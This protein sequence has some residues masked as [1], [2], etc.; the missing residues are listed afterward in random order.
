MSDHNPFAAPSN[1]GEVA[2]QSFPGAQQVDFASLQMAG[3]G[4]AIIYGAILFQVLGGIGFGVFGLA[5]IRQLTVAGAG[6]VILF[7]GI[8]MFLISLVSLIGACLCATVPRETE[9]KGWIVA[10]VAFQTAGFLLGLAARLFGLGAANG[11]PL[12]AIIPTVSVILFMVFLMKLGTHI[13]R[14]DLSRR[15]KR[16]LILIILGLIGVVVSSVMDMDV[17]GISPNRPELLLVFVFGLLYAL[18]VFVMYANIINAFS[19]YIR[20]PYASV[21]RNHLG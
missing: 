15:A 2:V 5:G 10:S 7:L 11:S 19:K 20:N 12:S 8:G 21:A 1:Q 9:A 6:G 18:F 3:T 14:P 17:R 4:L 13:C 16:I